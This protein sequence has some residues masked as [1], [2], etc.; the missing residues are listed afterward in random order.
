MEA[1]INK[2][3]PFS[4][5]D[6]P[7]NRT[8]IFFQGCN[9]DCKY[10]HNPETRALCISCG[11]CVST[12]PKSA[13]ELQ[14]DLSGNVKIVFDEK[15]CIACDTCIKNCRHSASPR[16]KSMS[17]DDVL[18]VIKKHMPFI[19]GITVSGGECMLNAAFLQE[20]FVKTRELGLSNFIDSNGTID[21][22]EYMQLLAVTDGVM[23]DV[24]AAYDEDHV[25]ITGHTNETVLKNLVFL[26]DEKKLFEVRV[27]VAPDLYDALKSVK[28]IVDILMPFKDEENIRVKLIAYRP[29]GVR[30]AYKYLNT[31]STA[32]MNELNDYLLQC[33]F[34]DVI[35]I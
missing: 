32:V 3:I 8:A 7:G 21:F 14:K 20:L 22:S 26:A 2:I 35:Q 15:K 9:I 33:G 28:K 25:S 4:S 16:T 34:S 6:G 27:V 1:I 29:M 5:V 17:V 13:L 24:K 30:E 10:C 19:R 23:L 12:C 11:E 18:Y 31:P